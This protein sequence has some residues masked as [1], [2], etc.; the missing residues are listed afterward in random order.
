MGNI[1]PS[2]Q[3][4]EVLPLPDYVLDEVD[5]RLLERAAAERDRQKDT[6]ERAPR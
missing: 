4:Y 3:R 2:R 6:R 5:R 1:G